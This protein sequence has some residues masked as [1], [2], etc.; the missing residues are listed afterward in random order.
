MINKNHILPVIT[1]E[2][3]TNETKSLPIYALWSNASLVNDA[4]I[5]LKLKKFINVQN[6]QKIR[7]QRLVEWKE[8]ALHVQF[9]RETES[10]DDGCSSE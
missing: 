9:M 1:E 2:C 5:E 4:K 8:E 7:N 3:V 6:K 10:T